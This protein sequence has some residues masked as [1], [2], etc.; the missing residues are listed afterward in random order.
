M[1][2]SH[3]SHDNLKVGYLGQPQRIFYEVIFR[4]LSWNLDDTK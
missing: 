2:L 4:G 3:T 1:T